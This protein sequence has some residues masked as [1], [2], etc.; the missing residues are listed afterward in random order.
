[1]KPSSAPRRVV[2]TGVGAIS[3]IGLDTASYW[4]GLRNGV[5]GLGP[6]TQFEA[7]DYPSRIAFE[8]KGFEPE[9]WMD[10]K[11]ARRIDRYAQFAICGTAQAL[12]DAGLDLGKEDLDRIGVVIGSGIGGFHTQEEQHTLLVQRGPNRISPFLIPMLIINLASGLVAMRHKIRGPNFAVVTACASGAHAI[13]QAA[14]VIERGDADVMV[15]GGAESAITPFAYAGFCNMGALSTRNDAG[16][17]ACC[18]FDARR[19][20]F[21]MGEGAGIVVLESLEHAQARGARIL[22]EVIGYGSSGDAHHMTAPDPEGRGAAL[23]MR[24]CLEDAG[25]KPEEIDY[26]NA[27]GTST[28]LNDKC[29]TK[30]VKEVF[31]AAARKVAIS[32]T[33]SMVGHTL[34]ASG[35]LE[36]VAIILAARDG[37]IPPTI[38]YAQPDPECDLD[39]TPNRGVAREVR[40]AMSNSF[41]FGG[42]NAVL[43]VRKWEKTGQKS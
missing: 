24:R 4:E 7:K 39:Y 8:V 41:G 5:S 40:V 17:A 12:A 33:K 31:G 16:P 22:A 10:R 6:I 37:F 23:A 36:F 28:Q 3:A 15:T 42:Q 2:V 30:A 43:M 14:R 38:N 20:G 11:E 25:V 34:G 19:D 18:P 27:H 13:G 26:L 9:K 21:I 35:A 29:E 1:M 32:S